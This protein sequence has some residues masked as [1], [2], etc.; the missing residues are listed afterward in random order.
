MDNQ[1]QPVRLSYRLLSYLIC[2]LIAWQPLLPAIAAGITPASKGTQLDKAAN[3]VPVINIAT[4][5]QAGLSHNQYQNY[6]VGKEGLILN[7]ATGQLNPTQLGGLIQ[8]NPN[9]KAGQEAKAIINEV[10]GANRSQLQG[11]T[12][13][14]GKAANVMV[15]NPYGITCNGCGFINTPNAT[16]TTGKPIMDAQG[17]LQALT[18]SKGTITV[19]GQ[20][21]DASQSD[22][23]AIISRATEINAAIHAQDLKLIAG[24]NRVDKNGAATPIAGEG[25]APG[26]AVDTGAL[27]GMYANRIHLVSS[28]KGVGVNLGNLNARQGD[29]VLDASG[30]LTLKN[31]LTSGALTA[32]GESIALNGDH[33][34]GGAVTLN[35][36]QAVTVN[37]GSLLSDD[38]ISLSSDGQVALNHGKLTAKKAIQL[39]A[40]E[41]KTDKASTADS[42]GNIGLTAR[43]KVDNAAQLTAGNALTLTAKQAKNS[44]ALLAQQQTLHADTLE[45]SGQIQGGSTLDITAAQLANSGAM[46]SNDALTL[47][48]EQLTNSG[49]MQGNQTLALTT[50]TLD[51]RGTLSADS[52]TLTGKNLTNSGKI[53]GGKRSDISADRL[54]QNGTLSAQGTAQIAVAQQ[55]DNG[56]E[57]SAQQALAIHS[58]S[59]FN[60]GSLIAPQLTFNG[61]Q[62]S[63]KGV[64]QG[65][66]TLQIRADELNNG[67]SLMGDDLLIH[68]KN[69][70]NS[71]KFLGGT[72][73]EISAD[74]LTQSGTINSDNTHLTVADTLDNSGAIAGQDALTI[75]SNHLFNQGSLTAPQLMLSSPQ[76]TNSG[77]I[78]GSKNLALSAEQLDNLH[79][80]SIASASD[81]TLDLP[82]LN[83]SGLIKSDAGLLLSG[84][85]LTNSGEINAATLNAS[86]NQLIN[87][88]GGKLLAQGAMQL[89]QKQLSN[90]GELA[91]ERL[92]INAQALHNSGLLQ[93]N[94]DL[95]ITS[96][97]LTNGGTLLSGGK[98]TLQSDSLDNQGLMQGDTLSLTAND[99]Q[100]SGNA[101]SEHD[102]DL[103]SKTLRNSG[104][105][106]GQHKV[107]LQADSSDNSGWLVAQALALRGDLINSG[108]LQGNDALTLQSG[109]LGNQR[110]GQLLSGG[111][112]DLATTQLD[113]QGVLQADTLR[114]KAQNWQN[115][116]S[117]RGTSLLDAQI[118]NNL[119]N[120]GYLLGEQA[121]TLTSNSIINQ[122]QLAADRLSLSASQLTNGGLLQ[123][124]SA[125]TLN[126]AQLYNQQDGELLSGAPL[127][128]TLDRLDNDGLLQVDGALDITAREASNGGN[129]LADNISAQV[130]ETLTNNG[131]LLAKQQARLDAQRLDNKGALAAQNLTLTA[132]TL[133]NRGALQG[134]T[135]LDISAQQLDNQTSGTLLSGNSL[136]LHGDRFSNDG[137]LQ[138]QQ[139]D[140]QG[141]TLINRG[142]INGIDQLT[143]SLRD[144]LNNGG[145]LLSQGNASLTANQLAN[146]GKM[147]ADGLTLRGQTLNN[148]GLWQGS[149]LL[150]AQGSS[151]TSAA[152]SRTLSGGLLTLNADQLTTAGTLQG[153]Q[154]QVSANGWQHQGS[155]LGNS[156][157]TA[158]VA[159]QL[160]NNGDLLSQ[161]GAQIHAQNLNNQ[162]SLLS[163]GAMTLTGNSL[164]NSGSVQGKT[165]HI[166]PAQV[167][168]QGSLIGLQALTL[169]ALPQTMG[170]MMLMAL[171]TPAREL[172]NN[173]GGALLTQGTLTINGDK[174]TN[175]GS[176]QGQQILL[177]AQRLTNGG[178][179]QSADGMQLILSDKLDAA[180]GSKISAN[181]TAAL[182]ALALTNQGQWVANNLTLNGNS[183]TNGGDISGV[184][185]LTVKL[186]GALTQQQDKTLLTAGKLDLQ[187]AS[188]N[189]AGRIQGGELQVTSGALEN[190]G[191]L[192][193]DSNLLMTLSGRLTNA[194]N[195]TLL[196]QKALTVTTPELY[197]SGLIQGGTTSGIHATG[198]TNN[199]GKILSGGELTL[200]TPQLTNGGWLQATQLIL[201]ASNANNSGTLL[202]QQQGTLTG[203][204]L[205][206]QG[207]VQGNNL[208]VNYQQLTNGG[209]LLG[210][211]QLNVT[212]A[213]VNQQ[214]AGK[215]FSGGNLILNSNGLDQPGQIVALGDA[216]LKLINA[217]TNQGTL[218]A[219]NRLS[220]SSN[221]ALANQGTMQG[222]ALTLGAGGDLINNGQLTSGS[223][224]STLS[225]NRIAMNGSG[226]LQGGGNINLTSRSDI[227]LDGFTGTL[228]NLTLSA[229]GSI[230]NS[231]LLYAA[232][233]L[234]LY[235]NSIKNQQGD[236]LAGNSLWMQRDAAGNANSEVVNTSG[237]IE[238]QNGDITVKTGHLLNERA[239]FSVSE[240]P[241]ASAAIPAWATGNATVAIPV[242][243][244]PAGSYGVYY[245]EGQRY[246]GHGD[247]WYEKV[248]HYAPYAKADEQKVPVSVTAVTVNPGGNQSRISSGRDLSGQINNLDN[249]ASTILAGRNIALSGDNLNNKS[250]TDGTTTQYNTYRYGV[251]NKKPPRPTSGAGGSPKSKSISY[252]LVG[253]PT[254]ETV[255]SGNVYRGVIQAAGNIT[256]NFSSDIS[257]SNTSPGVAGVTSGLTAPALSRL[258]NLTAL[259][260]QQQQS[261]ASADN[262]AVGSPQWRDQLQNALQAINGGGSLESNGASGAALN[263]YNNSR[264]GASALEKAAQ[265]ASANT[266]GQA[267][268]NYQ[269]N[270]V[271]TSAYPLPS[272]DNGYFVPAADANSHYLITVNPK[273]NGLGQLD[274]GLYGDLYSLLGTQP[275]TA[276]AQET[277]TQF[278][279]E[280]AF[281]G[282][283]YLLDRLNVHPDY[284]YR[285]LGDAA[286][287][288]RYVS[289]T[290][291]NQTGSRYINGIGSDLEQMRYLMDN[292]AAAQQSLGLQLGVSLTAAQIAALDHSIIWWEAATVNGETVM[293]PKVYLSPK[294]VTVNNGSVIAGNN[295][296]LDAGNITNSGSTLIAK[297]DLNLDSQNSIS[298]LNQG[299]INAGGDLQLSA[300]NDIN[301][302]GSTISGKKVA[303][304]SLDG[305]I[306]NLTQSK[307]IKIDGTGYFGNKISLTETMVGDRASINAADALSL[308]S[309]KDIAVQDADIKSGGNLLMNA[310]GDIAVT[311]N[312]INQAQS[313]TIRGNTKGN[314]STTWQGSNISAGGQLA[315]HADNNLSLSASTLNAGKDAALSAGNDLNLNA[316]T[317]QQNSRNGKSESHASGLERTTIS[318]GGDLKL[319]AGRD[320]TSQAAGLA[321]EGDV[322]LQAGRDLNLQAEATRSGNSYKAGKKQEI[323]EHVRQQG[324]EI[325]SG[326][327]TALLAGR[328][329]NSSAT[330]VTAQQ[331][332][333]VA[334]GHDVNLNTATESDYHYKEETKTKKGFLKK[335]TTHTIEED[336]ATREAGTLLSGNNVAVTAGHDLLVK[337]SQVVGD[338]SVA[339]K[340][341]NNV[342]IAA[343]TN[344][345]SS[346]R[347]K[348][349]KKSGLM[350]SGGI[351]FTI[352]SSKSVHDLREKGTTQSQSVSTVG[353]T[354]GDVT[355]TSGGQTH[356]AGADLVA[357]KSLNINGDAVVIEPGHDKRTRDERFE[358]K[359]SGLTLALSG[360]VGEA[361]NSAVATAQ[362][363][364][365]ESDGRLVALQATKTALSGVQA[366]LTAQQSAVSGEPADLVGVSISL[367][368]QKSKSQQHQR[369]DTVNGSTLNA[370]KNLSITA[371][372]K[373]DS[374]HSGDILIGGSQMKVAGDSTLN[375]ARDILLTG[376]AST[377]ETSGKNSS[378]GGGIGVSISAGQKTGFSIFANVNGAKGKENGDGTHWSET[379]LDSGGNVALNSGRDAT[380][381]GAQVTGNNV[382]A[383][384]GRD[385]LIRSQQDSDRYDSKQTSFG[386]GGSYGFSTMP[387]SGYVSV[388]QDKMRS[389]YSSVQEQSGI[390]AGEGGFDITTGNHTQLDGAVIAST[391]EAGKN[392]LDTGTLGFSDIG[393]AADY[394]VSHSGISAGLSSA[395]PLGGQLLSNALSNATGT[396]LAGLG[397]K[398]H[399]EGTTQAAVADGTITLRN[400]QQQQQN[401]NDLSRDTE[402]ANGSISPIFDKEKEQKRLQMAQMAGEI[403]GQMST[404]VQTQGDIRGLEAAKAAGI[405]GTASELRDSDAYKTAQ[406]DF[407]T[408]G[409]WQMVTQSVSGILSGLA[410]GNAMQAA[411]GALN[412]WVAQVIK[413]QTTDA[414]GN[415]NVAAN[416][417]AHAVWGAV[418]AQMAGG[419]AAA[420]AAGAFSGELAARYIAEHYYH[421]DLSKPGSELTEDE[422]QQLSLM[423]TLAAG[424]AGGLAGNSTAAA[425]TGAQAG[426]NAVENNSLSGEDAQ[427][428][429][430]IELALSKTGLALH[431]RTPEEVAELESRHEQLVRLDAEIDKYA[432][433]ACAKGK[434]S[435]ACQDANALLQ[436]LK[437]SYNGY[438][439][440]LTYRDLNREDYAKVSQIVANT[441]ADKWDYAIEGY[442]KS[443]NISYQEA[444]DKFAIAVNI[445]RMADVAAI[446][447]G[448]NG[449]GAGKAAVSGAAATL[450]TVLSK[451]D[452]FKQNI[453][454]STKGNNDALAMAGAGAPVSIGAAG[455]VGADKPKG[456]VVNTEKVAAE[457]T[458]KDESAG[459]KLL[460]INA[461]AGSKR[462]W[463][464]AI[465]GDLEANARYR[466]SNGH[467]YITDN[468]GRVTTVEGKLSLTTMDRNTYQQCAMGKCGNPGDDG[469]HLIASSLGG[470]G[471]KINIVPQSRTLNRQDWKRME[472]SLRNE[473]NAGKAVS[474]KIDVGYP[475]GGG[476]RPDAFR[477]TAII[478]GVPKTYTF[479]Q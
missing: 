101:L 99:W 122:G 447:Y 186:N 165:L 308:S 353:S 369:S 115:S 472:N 261:L 140:I 145:S 16:L 405:K 85:S 121:L 245:T 144:E 124:N 128:L 46:R 293:V 356:V 90:D 401:L 44:G 219:G 297:A 423:S 194:A 254:Y 452:E 406:R 220:V 137:S 45:N 57:T 349:T 311:A 229:P 199:S 453:A 14:A 325:A 176:W 169:G 76:L 93:G 195:G 19:E 170:R 387:V 362:A 350:G 460:D 108:L 461:D 18:V 223:G 148:N 354:G 426:K 79:G 47:N 459:K 113:N 86:H 141:N 84:D 389:R 111:T 214:P 458:G 450:K 83:N 445:N 316:A 197:N 221:G 32:K 428:K 225:G 164:N 429:N 154:A 315:M 123:G 53:L 235:A 295:V 177:N 403:A 73:S 135:L 385:L 102:A 230:V 52:L 244:L 246:H 299:L 373:G 88:H 255:G 279:N 179:I 283:S 341:G 469:G 411:A 178:A 175:N 289:N 104:K 163:A 206:N 274:K 300:L 292:A 253:A 319:A 159:G 30:K 224:D 410:G 98:L 372:G 95:A 41:I 190:R 125:L 339:L 23:L 455:T 87:Q 379:T 435:E 326:G 62:L 397:G 446:L 257:N 352:G 171:A 157:F 251:G 155:L 335:K 28:E 237:T 282:S 239:G 264:K 404:I 139:V 413:Q 54:T 200:N 100:N 433:D 310:W 393:N 305:S 358:Q 166:A 314:P 367:T 359:T 9:L 58:D 421:V 226:T 119:Y 347:F 66:R 439:G 312:E 198:L 89:E 158:D 462:N 479:I 39:N 55:L 15:A 172:I 143:G 217:F 232:N 377:Q 50:G 322:A 268:N 470:A 189:N 337:G 210:N 407:G 203:S 330:Q 415:V 34:A 92:N 78:Q 473:M 432:Q 38:A 392:H 184:N 442:A 331:D 329:L 348:E 351:G 234:Y 63:N 227:A 400:Q 191:R 228:G 321:A 365:S 6:N 80:G 266:T 258:T 371:N 465:N 134:D 152:G 96:S 29:M 209:T 476:V 269:G 298:N 207:S 360:A 109:T 288:T 8:N 376:A 399:A 250:W 252:T 366:A 384:I 2:A 448:L 12:E 131:E 286:F 370:G 374:A 247:D 60:Q 294:D 185:G 418:A 181:G 333:A 218:A 180:A 106:L 368:T 127:A 451:Y 340:A 74:R 471:D 160:T 21:L 222:Q 277:R 467:E 1:Q 438:V 430:S 142:S 388:S 441:S 81:L 56:G 285:F 260:A 132:D 117:A 464:K 48:A 118:D 271:D 408:G 304:E 33:K 474:V 276:P 26:V 153:E 215:L 357:G 94:K 211:N 256:A 263:H 345:D 70:T 10:T 336:S 381:N 149:S 270:P 51:N 22:A 138:G 208:S 64:I 332:I 273:L 114:V 97:D 409:K 42:G 361:V 156:G 43:N 468:T 327:D 301:N 302:I 444:K 182:Q 126:S 236:V 281:L 59:L 17:N 291:I 265:L 20:G 449:S 307:Q 278:T 110:A 390:F 440:Q 193:G 363:A 167:I 422:R 213:Q 419:N 420:G 317:T 161:N 151:L 324:T 343:A 427:E 272:G 328:D 212:A 284:D 77:L 202:A 275:E 68:G 233:N 248:P 174:V 187:A 443:Q 249:L 7:N 267:L 133:H 240:Q 454:A 5:N 129:M 49:E 116:G 296:K 437:E 112:L 242:S 65:N 303:L 183:L 477:V 168:N 37:A 386:A 318:S 241:T 382:T 313:Q 344:T 391:A 290:V 69:L 417:A 4:P 196:S 216:T 231:A 3:G 457:V 36:A 466:L 204:S 309:G 27:G 355:I 162:G 259:K 412:P 146:S 364:K 436:G 24:A 375:A 188:V 396:L 416:A 105:I 306:N 67:G 478:D 262:L 147:L 475:A 431:P 82:V 107:Q 61:Q 463:D 150:D 13:V 205:N 201:N 434:A 380:L 456:G 91:A 394:K 414:K 72:R 342:E 31:S 398:G 11:Y 130:S 320:L 40:A 383:D 280:K 136:R 243:W 120:G 192:Q 25:T 424:L 334:A 173:Q 287:D 75:I 71:G 346:W 323:N 238:T 103:H 395:G 35:G 402:H 425:T 338:D 378:S